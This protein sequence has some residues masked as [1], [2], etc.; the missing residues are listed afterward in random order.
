MP[1]P[2]AVHDLTV[3][4]N[5]TFRD[6]LSKLQSSARGILLL[7]DDDGR[8][9]RTVTDGDVR[10]HLLAG[11]VLS[12]PLARTEPATPVVAREPCL[13]AQA[14]AMMDRH[15]VDHLPVLD[16]DGRVVELLLRKEL[17]KPILLSLS[18]IHI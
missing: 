12:D 11:A 2:P 10:R 7:V 18:L 14:L 5:D 16:S 9:L 4:Q 1:V 15:Q 6:A 17:A 8:L 3:R 13:P